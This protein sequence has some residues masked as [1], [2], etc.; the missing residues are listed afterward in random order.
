MWVAIMTTGHSFARPCCRLTDATGVVLEHDFANRTLRGRV[1][2]LV[3]SLDRQ[4]ARH[5]S[6]TNHLPAVGN[7]SILAAAVTE[8]ACESEESESGRT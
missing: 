7:V 5:S 2:K 1:E 6:T 4:T 8:W 3:I